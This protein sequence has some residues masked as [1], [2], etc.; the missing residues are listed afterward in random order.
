M[1]L[2]STT[3]RQVSFSRRRFRPATGAALVLVGLSLAMVAPI[4]PLARLTGLDAVSAAVLMPLVQ[5]GHGV[6]GMAEEVFLGAW[7]SDDLRA[8]NE[9]LR[10]EL[11]AARLELANTQDAQAGA[12]I[13]GELATNLPAAASR[14]LAATVLAPVLDDR[15]RLLWI[16]AG[17]RQGL[18]EGQVVLGTSGVVGTVSQVNGETAMVRLITDASSK[19]GGEVAVRGHSGLVEGTGSAGAVAFH[20]EVTGVELAE[21]DVVTTTGRRGSS[22]PSGLPLGTVRSVE[23]NAAG[24]RHAVLDP[25]DHPES[26][27]TV[28]VLESTQLAWRPPGEVKP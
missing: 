3:L 10:A 1:P 2:R 28:F 14:V 9:A 17:A 27:R 18:R 19:W 5:A 20:P 21:G 12:E 24:E 11:V 22:V 15:R 25:A 26:A 7:Q 6:R 13:R 23:V 16:G 4:S 8:E